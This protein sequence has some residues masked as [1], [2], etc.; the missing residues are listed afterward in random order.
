MRLGI[1]FGTTRIVVA[2]ADRGNFPL[3][4]FDAGDAAVDWFPPLVAI[5]GEERRYGWDAW[6][7]QTEP[8]WTI[9]RSLKRYLEDAGPH[10]CLDAGGEQTPLLTLL[11][12]EGRSPK[13]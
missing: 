9:V 7:A 11:T 6:N 5:Q 2:A 1:D 8:G 3:V 10:T 12:G 4:P 13:K